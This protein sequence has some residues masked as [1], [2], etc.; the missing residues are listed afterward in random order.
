MKNVYIYLIFFLIVI[1]IWNNAH[2]LN[3][4]EHYTGADLHNI[5]SLYASGKLSAP[6]LYTQQIESTSPTSYVTTGAIS[7]SGNLTAPNITSSTEELTD[8][9]ESL[10]QNKNIKKM[11]ITSKITQL[12]TKIDM[13]VAT[14]KIP[15]TSSKLITDRDEIRFTSSGSPARLSMIN[16]K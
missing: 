6:I 3:L 7:V 2:K 10:L 14:Y 13:L 16:K 9:Y 8:K 1:L 11:D 12:K 5:S 15:C 4:Y